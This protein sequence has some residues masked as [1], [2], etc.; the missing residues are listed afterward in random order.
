M[1]PFSA[2]VRAEVDEHE[3]VTRIAGA[4]LDIASAYRT[5]QPAIAGKVRD[6]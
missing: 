1:D 5:A 2:L 4:Y 6:R 3:T